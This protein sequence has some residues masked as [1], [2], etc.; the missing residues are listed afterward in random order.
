M[1]ILDA[2]QTTLLVDGC[3]VRSI[4]T[5]LIALL[6]DEEEDATQCYHA[7]A[8]ADVLQFIIIEKL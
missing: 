8:Q 6:Q 2:K 5:L 1:P 7:K 3:L 4:V